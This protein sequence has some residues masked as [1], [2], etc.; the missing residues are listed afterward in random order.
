MIKIGDVIK[1]KIGEIAEMAGVSRRTIDYYTNL[2]LLKPVRSESNYRYYTQ[3]A[4][5]RL[6][7]IEI[8]KN[9]RF[10]LDEIKAR[11]SFFDITSPQAGKSKSQVKTV[12]LDVLVQE[13]KELEKQLEQLKPSLKDMDADQASMVTKQVMLRT[14]SLMQAMILYI[15]ELTPYV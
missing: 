5:V 8:M 11:F 10:T 4:L 15:S 2:G 1:F 6:K 12:T 14:M 9:Q 7:F 3:D 13:F